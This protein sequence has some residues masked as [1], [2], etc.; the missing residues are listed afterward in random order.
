MVHLNQLRQQNSLTA[1]MIYSGLSGYKPYLEADIAMGNLKLLS[2]QM[3]LD[4]QPIPGS[5]V[6]NPF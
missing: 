6:L 4:I 3:K 1:A 5:E 2:A